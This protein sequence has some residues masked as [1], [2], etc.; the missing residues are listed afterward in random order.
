MLNLIELPPPPPLPKLV[1]LP[2]LLLLVL[3]KKNVVATV[4][5]LVMLVLFPGASVAV[6]A[7]KP[8]LQKDCAHFHKD[9]RSSSS[10]V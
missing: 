5:F 9:G 6:T 8:Q 4:N 10:V 2:L 1:L 7:A 3:L